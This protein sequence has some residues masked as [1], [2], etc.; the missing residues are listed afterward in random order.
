MATGPPPL[1]APRRQPPTGPG[2]A[3]APKARPTPVARTQEGRRAQLKQT[4]DLPQRGVVPAGPRRRAVHGVSR[5]ARHRLRP[6]RAAGHGELVDFA[7]TTPRRK[8][9]TCHNGLFGN[10]CPVGRSPG[11]PSWLDS[12]ERRRVHFPGRHS[13]RSHEANT[14][15]PRPYNASRTAH[16]PAWGTQTQ[17]THKLEAVTLTVTGTLAGTKFGQAGTGTFVGYNEQANR[18]YFTAFFQFTLT[19]PGTGD[20]VG[21]PMQSV[22]G[23][24]CPSNNTF[25]M[26]VNPL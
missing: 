4:A 7:R 24:V 9:T 14:P 16:N 12:P 5:P 8:S 21:G 20:L 25:Y 13:V 11:G 18:Y 1:N 22:S 10:N 2:P 3:T 6:C 15:R 17:G 26:Q 19:T 23:W